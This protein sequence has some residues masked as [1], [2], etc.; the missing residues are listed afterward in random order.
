MAI[1][2]H[3]N[4]VSAGLKSKN[5]LK[6]WL[7]D[8]IGLENARAGKINIVFTTDSQ[9]L[10]LNKKYL[11]RDYLTDILAFE[12]AD[13]QEVD[14]DLFISVERVKENSDSFNVS[15]KNELKRVIVHGILHLLGY[16]DGTE[17]EKSLMTQMEDHY[18]LISPAI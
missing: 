14:G 9:L 13:S 5:L 10:E 7:N 16:K 11:S 4:E 3:E 1:I 18:L 2:F 17:N 6:K 8:V 12:Y 15:F